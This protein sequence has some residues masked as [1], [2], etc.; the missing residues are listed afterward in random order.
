ML[1]IENLSFSYD[2]KKVL[3]NINLS[4]NRGKSYAIVG[5]SGCGK[6]TLL[7]VL[8]GLENKYVGNIKYNS[9]VID[10]AS[11]SKYHR[12]NVSIIFQN[13]NLIDYLTINENII[14]E[15]RIR[16]K[17][18]VSLDEIDR[19]FEE[20][21]IEEIDKSDYP[22]KLSGGQQQRIAIIR[23]IL[24]DTDIILADEPTASLDKHNSD[25][26]IDKLNGIA[27]DFNKIVI[28]VTHDKS[29]ADKCDVSIELASKNK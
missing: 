15:H 21:D 22:C 5:K 18:I 3:D 20:F 13:L 1:Q 25:A 23:T 17:K 11:I 29:I 12:E 16:R 2:D 28:I 6:T 27:K 14:E 9:K 8:G 4:F 19:L 26:I 10:K 7:S 24:S